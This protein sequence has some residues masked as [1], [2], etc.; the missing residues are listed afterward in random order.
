MKANAKLLC[1]AVALALSAAVHAEEYALLKAKVELLVEDA[2]G[3]YEESFRK[4]SESYG[5]PYQ[6]YF[7]LMY[8]TGSSLLKREESPATRLRLKKYYDLLEK[9]YEA[10]TKVEAEAAKAAATGGDKVL[11][12]KRVVSNGS[13]HRAKRLIN[14]EK[15]RDKELADAVKRRESFATQVKRE[16]TDVEKKR[17]RQLKRQQQLQKQEQQKQLQL[18]QEQ[19]KQDQAQ[20]EEPKQG[21]PQQQPQN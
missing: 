5:A 9:D 6:Y 11:V 15:L 20:Q 3:F 14:A 13:R 8:E 19:Q 12:G 7:G 2:K 4:G 1:A 17:Q 18:K 21:S 10:Y 16:Q